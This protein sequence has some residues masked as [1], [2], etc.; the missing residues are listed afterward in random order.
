MC[1]VAFG[2]EYRFTS[3]FGD[4]GVLAIAFA[5]EGSGHFHTV[6]VQLVLVFVHFCDIVV[7]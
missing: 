6:V 1:R 7:H 4:E 2:Y 3:I 5:L